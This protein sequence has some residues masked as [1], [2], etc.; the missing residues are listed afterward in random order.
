MRLGR[1]I[2]LVSMLSAVVASGC[3]KPPKSDGGSDKETARPDPDAKGKKKKGEADEIVFTKKVP[4]VGTIV[5]EKQSMQMEM[6]L[7]LDMKGSKPITIEIGKTDTQVKREKVLATDGKATTKLEVTYVSKEEMEKEKG[8]E[9]TK[10][11]PVLGKTYVVELKDGKP[12]VTTDKGLPAPPA[13]AAIVAKENKS[14]GKPEPTTEG[15]PDGPIKV[16]EKVDSLAR[17]IKE[18]VNEGDAEISDVS[19]KLKEIRT[20]DGGKEG[21]FEVAITFSMDKPGEPMK[22]KMELSGTM[23]LRRDDTWPVSLELGGPITMGGHDES[24]KGG[25]PGMTGKGKVKMSFSMSYP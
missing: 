7:V 6:E 2:A 11:S 10:T 20:G 13:E 21:V 23:S 15:M 19:V 12:Y 14:I 16:G 3:K 18:R 4:A 25:P 17:A 24:T 9:K 8:T 1:T 5:E 22:M